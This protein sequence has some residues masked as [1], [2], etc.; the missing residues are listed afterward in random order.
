MYYSKHLHIY[1]VQI[2]V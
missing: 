1:Y 2:I